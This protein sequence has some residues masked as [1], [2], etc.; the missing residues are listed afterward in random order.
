MDRRRQARTLT[1]P[2]RPRIY[3]DS[4]IWIS[5]ITYDREIF[6][7]RQR[8]QIG[9]SL[10]RAVDRRDAVALAS[11]L[12]E[13][14]VLRH[15]ESKQRDREHVRLIRSLFASDLVEWADVDRLVVR[16][17]AELSDQ[18][19]RM[20]SADLV[21]MATAIRQHADYLITND[22]GFPHGDTIK[23]VQIISPSVV[24][25]EELRDMP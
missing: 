3:A 9:Q 23:G 14:E 12:V 15:P 22:R 24:W 2:G 13:I 1:R 7:G 25:Q 18:Y 8:W 4:C 6:D 20:A 16:E 17:A 5:L 10:L 11:A 21:H 19:P